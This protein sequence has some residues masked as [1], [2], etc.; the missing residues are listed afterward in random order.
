MSYNYFPWF[1][2]PTKYRSSSPSSV[3]STSLSIPPSESSGKG[4]SLRNKFSMPRVRSNSRTPSYNDSRSKSSLPPSPRSTLFSNSPT[5]SEY[6]RTSSASS[7]R[8]SISPSPNDE[9]FVHPYAN[10]DLVLSYVSDPPPISPHRGQFSNISRSDS[11]STITDVQ[12]TSSHSTLMHMPSA[13]SP[14]QI[15]QPAPR[16]NITGRGISSPINS[17]RPNDLLPPKIKEPHVLA[18]P[19]PL[20]P[21]GIPGWMDNPGSPTIQLISLAEAQAQAKERARSATMNG[22]VLNPSV[23]FPDRYE[24]SPSP[25]NSMRS[26][27]RSISAGAKA[28]SALSNMIGGPPAAVPERRDSEPAISPTGVAGKSLKHRKSGFMRMFNGKDRETVPPVPTLA[29]EYTAHN[30]SHPPLVQNTPKISPSRASIPSLGS[31]S[32]DESPSSASSSSNLSDAGFPRVNLSP[33]RTPPPLHIHTSSHSPRTPA[34]ENLTLSMPTIDKSV[35]EG[36]V[37]LS[38]PPSTSDFPSLSLRPVS[39]IFSAHF[40]DHIVALQADSDFPAKEEP[41]SDTPMSS[42]P[43]TERSPLTSGFSLRSD[44]TTTDSGSITA[45]DSEDQSSVIQT[46]REQIV[47]A[48]KAWQHHIWEL[49]GQVR[50]LKAEVDNLRSAG[51][52]KE[53]CEVCG[54]GEPVQDGHNDTRKVGVVNRPRARTGDAA[55]FGNGK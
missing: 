33:K 46:L 32:I 55:R 22:V 41:A 5:T 45:N 52:W 40:A 38:A 20:G 15:D 28:K 11:I 12:S 3:S 43:G 14:R 31:Y 44:E 39:T 37:P 30:N 53:Y 18:R 16:A 21:N 23:P 34:K 7:S 1:L 54:R 2:L 50:D 48:R 13:S 27:A 25:I 4:S 47:S 10:P 36:G 19:P 35:K 42:S 17:F 26:R 51:H 9:D 24:K 6:S 49:E 8:P 29:D